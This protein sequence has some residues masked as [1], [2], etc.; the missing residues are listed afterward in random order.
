MLN[1]FP[2]VLFLY[3]LGGEGAQQ[4]GWHNDTFRWER[5]TGIAILSRG[6]IEVMV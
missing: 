2:V 4:V 3:F 6:A 1:E 5:S